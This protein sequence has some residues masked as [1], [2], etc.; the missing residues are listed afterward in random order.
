[1]AHLAW[2]ASALV[3]E[4]AFRGDPSYRRSLHPP[5]TRTIGTPGQVVSHML[6]SST[7]DQLT[8]AAIAAV[9][10]WPPWPNRS[11]RAPIKVRKVITLAF[12]AA[13][14]KHPNLANL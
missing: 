11:E 10:K 2:V 3:P 12:R 5:M 6:R 4:P 9:Q 7:G 13:R 14:R 1:M 8:S